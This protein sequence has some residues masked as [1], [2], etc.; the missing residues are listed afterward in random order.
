MV[1][2]RTRSQEDTQVVAGTAQGV[3]RTPKSSWANLA[4]Q[5]K[6]EIE[7]KSASSRWNQARRKSGICTDIGRGCPGKAVNRGPAEKLLV[8]SKEFY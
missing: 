4:T 2:S 5:P 3:C 8:R 1:Q 6:T 7:A